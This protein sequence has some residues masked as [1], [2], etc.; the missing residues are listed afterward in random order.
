ML[1][2]VFILNRYPVPGKGGKREER[3]DFKNESFYC[4]VLV[5]EMPGGFIGFMPGQKKQKTL[6][7]SCVK[8]TGI[9]FSVPSS[10]FFLKK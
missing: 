7:L 3:A 9:G 10:K 1:L 8:L 2:P 6:S 5:L 4:V